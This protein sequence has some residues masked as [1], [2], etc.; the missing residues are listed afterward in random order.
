MHIGALE[1]TGVFRLVWTSKHLETGRLV[2]N[3]L[4]L[5]WGCGVG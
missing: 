4:Q 3:L 2:R 5:V 1:T